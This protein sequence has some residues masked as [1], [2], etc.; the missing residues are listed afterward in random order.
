VRPKSPKSVRA[1]E[2]R[3]DAVDARHERHPHRRIVERL[4]DEPPDVLAAVPP[5]DPA[6]DPAHVGHVIARQD[7]DVGPVARE[8]VEVV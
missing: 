8:R 2:A 4:V 3:D 6:V 1:D 7:P 5:G